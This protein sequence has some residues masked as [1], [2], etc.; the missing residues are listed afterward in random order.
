MLSLKIAFRFLNSNAGQSVM[1]IGGMAVAVSIQV[2]VGLLISSLQ[3]TL[4]NSTVRNLPQITITSDTKVPS[5]YDW[6]YIRDRII[7]TGLVSA[8]SPATIGNAYTAKDG[9]NYPLQ[10][11]GVQIEDADHIYN[12]TRAVYAG[13]INVGNREAL[14]GRQLAEQLN[15]SIGDKITAVTSSGTEIIFTIA[16]LY[17]LGVAS[18]NGTWVI[19]QMQTVQQLYDLPGRI[20]TLEISVNDIFAA[21]T[22]ASVIGRELNNGD[23][24]IDN[25]KDQNKELL[26]GLNS[27]GLSSAIIQVVIIISVIIAI[28]SVLAVSVVQKSRQI[29]ILKAMGI[30]DLD[31]SLIFVYEG[32]L[33]GLIGS[34]LGVS[35]G[36]FILSGFDRYGGGVI[37][38]QMDYGFVLASWLVALIS[39][40]MAALLPARKSLRLNPIDVIREG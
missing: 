40:V 10:L 12:L 7:R 33:L 21:D 15:L 8:V 38:V 25:W 36:L 2:F 37:K 19:A 22:I 20:T 16:G 14:I 27:Q 13:S 18:I 3:T 6:S 11:K 24:K 23:L 26:N 30:T 39:S 17:D 5:I 1:I 32:L 29:G 31:A 34:T 4:I 28:S 9:K 35:L